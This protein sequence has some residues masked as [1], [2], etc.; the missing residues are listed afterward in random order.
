MLYSNRVVT[1]SVV[2]DPEDN[3]LRSIRESLPTGM[4]GMLWK[5]MKLQ[6]LI[7]PQVD[8]TQIRIH[9]RN[10]SFFAAFLMTHSFHSTIYW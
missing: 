7:K 10:V 2:G 1:Q 5:K 6:Y 4:L 8:L 3:S 9:E